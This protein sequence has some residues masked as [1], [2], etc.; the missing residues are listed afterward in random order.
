VA[1]EI[2]RG[3]SSRLTT[4]ARRSVRTGTA[5]RPAAGRD[6]RYWIHQ[7][8][9]FDWHTLT[10]ADFA[11]GFVTSQRRFHALIGTDDPNL[12]RFRKR[13]GKMIIWHGEAD[14][15][16]FPRGTVN[17]FERVLAANGGLEQVSEFARL[18]LAPG[19]GH[20]GG[21]D[22]PARG[23][24]AR[25][26]AKSLPPEQRQPEARKKESPVASSVTSW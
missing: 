2:W 22:G 10:D 26:R 8:P 23:R 5:V 21:G 3:Q 9:T 13:G 17:Y 12:E 11:A 18:F 25:T 6:L 19:V 1:V 4:A 14:P 15:L 16:I 7:D 20:C 24:C